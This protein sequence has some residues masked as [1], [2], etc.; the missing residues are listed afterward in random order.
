MTARANTLAFPA[1]PNRGK[2]PEGAEGVILQRGH[3]GRLHGVGGGEAAADEQWSGRL[4][5]GEAVD[6]TDERAAAA[7]AADAGPGS[8]DRIEGG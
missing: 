5:D 2:A 6:G 7:A 3:P 4:V 1:S 8:G